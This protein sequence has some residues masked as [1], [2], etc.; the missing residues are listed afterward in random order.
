VPT[1]VPF[2]QTRAIPKLSYLPLSGDLS[3]ICC[4]KHTYSSQC[5]AAEGK[6]ASKSDNPCR[7]SQL[8]A[9]CGGLLDR[10]GNTSRPRAANRAGPQKHRRHIFY[11]AQFLN[12]AVTS[13]AA[14]RQHRS[15]V[16]RVAAGRLPIA[17]IIDEMPSGLSLPLAFGMYTLLIGSSGSWSRSWS[18]TSTMT[19]MDID[20]TNR[21]SMRLGGRGTD[22]APFAGV[23]RSRHA[24]IGSLVN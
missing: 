5:V 9:V 11:A 1:K 19:P 8:V 16:R 7:K 10:N 22:T 12:P 2:L 15:P 20:P 4:N 23:A 17:R 3:K 14:K 24:D 21:R 6:S 13:T 18:L